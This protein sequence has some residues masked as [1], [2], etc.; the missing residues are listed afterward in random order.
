MA[1]LHDLA[2]RNPSLSGRAKL[3][4]ILENEDKYARTR[5]YLVPAEGINPNEHASIL[6][7][8]SQHLRALYEDGSSVK[9][10]TTV[11]RAGE[12]RPA[13]SKV[14]ISDLS[15]TLQQIPDREQARRFY[16]A[17][18]TITGVVPTHEAKLVTFQHFYSEINKNEYGE[19]RT[20]EDRNAAIEQTIARMEEMANEI[21][22]VDEMYLKG[23]PLMAEQLTE[24]TLERDETDEFIEARFEEGYEQD[25]FELADAEFNSSADNITSNL[26][27]YAGLGGGSGV[28][29]IREEGLTLPSEATPAARE[30]YI[31]V[32]LPAIDKQLESG[33]N[34]AD[35][36]QS[37]YER[38]NDLHRGKF[39]EKVES[40]ADKTFIPPEEIAAKYQAMREGKTDQFASTESKIFASLNEGKDIA[41]LQS[42]YEFTQFSRMAAEERK[43]F[44]AMRVQNPELVKEQS[45]PGGVRV[46][47]ASGQEIPQR[48]PGVEQATGFLVAYITERMRDPTTRL[49]NE[50]P[51]FREAY[52][53][54][55]DREVKTVA[56]V[57]RASAEIIGTGRAAH[58]QLQAHLKDPGNVS[59]PEVRGLSYKERDYLFRGHMPDHYTAEM[60]EVRQAWGALPKER[61]QMKAGLANGTI[62]KSDSL[63]LLE[64]ELSKRTSV[65]A[66]NHL[67]AAIKGGNEN[68]LHFKEAYEKLGPHERDYFYEAKQ[69]RIAGFLKEP[70]LAREEAKPIDP[71]R[72]QTYRQYIAGVTERTNQLTQGKELTPA[73]TRSARE[74]AQARAWGDI[75]EEIVESA[76]PSPAE[77]RL[78]VLITNTQERLQVEARAGRDMKENFINTKLAEHE[79]QLRAER[80]ASTY[81]SAFR[82]EI[83]KDPIAARSYERVPSELLT[84][85][86]AENFDWD[87]V[88]VAATNGT[89]VE[90]QLAQIQN[91]E[92]EASFG[93]TAEVR[94]ERATDAD[95]LR[96]E[97]PQVEAMNNRLQSSGEAAH[98]IAYQEMEAVRQSPLY[99]TPQEREQVVNQLSEIMSPT[100]KEQLAAL[101]SYAEVTKD[102]F[103]ESFA[104]IDEQRQLVRNER[105]ERTMVDSTEKLSTIADNSD[106]RWWQNS[107]SA[108]AVPV[109]NIPSPVEIER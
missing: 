29:T 75:S 7:A 93:R 6:N 68:A 32:V 36:R 31:S 63:T 13:E 67:W 102:R 14:R 101:S 66:T 70:E 2:N 92:K 37:I 9:G 1:S 61:Q 100:D 52:N 27:E 18:N 16:D 4:E 10:E 80:N 88:K 72:S 39:S 84:R 109:T 30:R 76:Q 89:T 78:S 60:R 65:K 83:A 33:V 47:T 46:Y 21:R 25:M 77:A 34:P 79:P 11:I 91:A 20:P 104:K 19:T 96:A 3:M 48:D 15:Y 90:N 85:S 17:A 28:M 95:Q 54:L 51:Q 5:D 62:P 12:E 71:T 55:N 108:P 94:A 42:S 106:G 98:E 23:D 35:I 87:K 97:M 56:D 8:Q 82:R 50:S 43:T 53:W 38:A 45:R 103:L 74:T 81:T 99:T 57:N 58:T 64:N 40:L 105:A 26:D 86:V 49:L 22:P 73:E 24:T 59:K 107:Q 41:P 44:D 69:T